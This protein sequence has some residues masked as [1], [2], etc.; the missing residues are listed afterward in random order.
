MTRTSASNS[1]VVTGVAVVSCSASTFRSL[2]LRA[3]SSGRRRR[4]RATRRTPR[5][6]ARPAPDRPSGSRP[7]VADSRGARRDHPH[8]PEV[9][10]VDH[11][12]IAAG[13]DVGVG[14]ESDARSFTGATGRRGVEELL[15][16]VVAIVRRDPLGHEAVELVGVLPTRSPTLANF[17]E[18]VRRCRGRAAA[19]AARP[20]CRWSP[21]PRATCRRAVRYTLRGTPFATRLPVRR[22]GGRRRRSHA[23]DRA[24]E[25]LQ[26][27]LEHAHVDVLARA[28]ARVAVVAR[29]QRAHHAD[30]RGERVAERDRRQH[31]RAVGLAGEVR[32]P[33][34]RLGERAVAVAARVRTRSCRS[35][36]RSRRPRS[37]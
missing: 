35:S 34:E 17:A 6:C 5:H 12:D 9:G 7:G 33:A 31:R 16:H 23:R 21:R 32:E 30:D 19:G 37:G 28:A 27:R 20:G 36:S 3:A 4:G 25:Q 24:G 22:G 11:D 1:G 2:L 13:G 10:I 14:D 8:G 18:P 15:D 26:H 29:G